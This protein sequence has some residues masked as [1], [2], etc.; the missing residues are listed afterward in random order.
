MA[1]AFGSIVSLATAIACGGDDRPR[2]PE[3]ATWHVRLARSDSYPNY[4][5]DG[6]V[7]TAARTGQ[8]L[9]VA[10]NLGAWSVNGSVEHFQ[11]AVLLQLWIRKTGSE[12]AA[13][14]DIAVDLEPVGDRLRGWATIVLPDGTGSGHPGATA[15]A[16]L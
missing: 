3:Q 9:C 16:W 10:E 8:F 6:I 4:S 13:Q 5:C 15:E 2:F 1:R 11:S 7:D 12:N 14:P